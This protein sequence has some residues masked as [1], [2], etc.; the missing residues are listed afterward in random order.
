L[1]YKAGN[2]I[3]KL[4]LRSYEEKKNRVREDIRNSLSKIHISFDLW[5]SPGETLALC[6]VVAHYLNQSLQAK[7]LLLGLKEVEGSHLSE[8]LAVSYLPIIKDFE[9]KRKIEYFVSDNVN[10]ND[11]VIKTFYKYLKIKNALTRRL[12]YL[13]HVINLAAKAFLFNKEEGSFD[14]ETS[15]LNTM[16][17]AERQALKLLVF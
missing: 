16:K 6:A 3:K 14:F 8:N 2:S 10:S 15:E 1:L 9:L 13:R 4:V 5:T 7:S 12:R 17:F 11:L